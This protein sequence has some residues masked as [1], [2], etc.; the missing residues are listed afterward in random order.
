MGLSEESFILTVRI[1][2][3]TFLSERLHEAGCIE[4]Y[5]N[6]TFL[7]LIQIILY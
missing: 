7:T 6:H 1:L 3:L 4:H 2:S 5:N